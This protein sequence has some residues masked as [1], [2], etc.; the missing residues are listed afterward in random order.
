MNRLRNNFNLAI[1]VVLFA[2]LLGVMTFWLVNAGNR[3]GPDYEV[4]SGGVSATATPAPTA[5]PQPTATPGAGDSTLFAQ[6]L[7]SDTIRQTTHAVG[8]ITG[9]AVGVNQSIAGLAQDVIIAEPFFNANSSTSTSLLVLVISTAG[10]A[11]E[12][13]RVGLYQDSGDLAPDSLVIDMGTITIDSTGE[14]DVSFTTQN[15]TQNT[16]YWVA[17]V[18]ESSTV[19]LRAFTDPKDTYEN[20]LG[21]PKGNCNR[22]NWGYKADFTCGSGCSNSLSDPFSSTNIDVTDTA[23]DGPQ[24]SF[25]LDF[26]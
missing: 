8:C 4:P 18:T 2:A 1:L 10:S 9:C 12:T 26:D 19:R 15:L 20:P 7:E 6:R 16:W 22:V 5:T 25:W 23:I 11:G 17:F 3:P 13:A 21:C 14:I 24:P